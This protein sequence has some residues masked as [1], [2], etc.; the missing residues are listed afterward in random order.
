MMTAN[1]NLAGTTV[2]RE[3]IR[4][5]H[6][7]GQG[8]DDA[9][10]ALPLRPTILA[11]LTDL[12]QFEA[13]YPL[14]VHP[15]GTALPFREVVKE[16]E[17]AGIITS[18]FRTAMNGQS[19]VPL[20]DLAPAA[21]DS[22]VECSKAEVARLR[23][24][25]PAGAFL[26]GFHADSLVLLHAA[27]LA[28]A[29]R[30]QRTK[31]WE[32]V[33]HTASRLREIL[34]LD[35][36]H[37]PGAVSAASVT[38]S[39]GSR[40]GAFFNSALLAKAL[41]RPANPLKRMDAE[42]RSR[43][44]TTLAQLEEGLQDLASQPAFW[45][46]HSGIF[47]ATSAPAAV[48]LFH[49]DARFAVD[50]FAAALQ[51]CDTRL[52]RLTH[53]LRALRVARLEIESTFDPLIHEDMLARFDWQSASEAELNALPPIVVIETG[54]NLGQASLTSFGRL[55]R[56]GRPVQALILHGA[57]EPQDLRDFTPDFGYLAIAHRESFV[58]QSSM[59][60]PS[61]LLPGLAAM[62]KTLRPAVA[63]V[64]A[65]RREA[66][67]ERDAWLEECLQ[68]LS[69]AFPLYR[70]D[71]EA[72]ARWPERFQLLSHAATKD[73]LTA[74]HAAAVSDH[75][76]GQFR[77]L[78]PSAWN[79]EQMELPQYLEAYTQRP[80]LAIPYIWVEGENG[81]QQRAI[82][83]RDL[84]NFCVD[85]RRA[86]ALFDELGTVAKPQPVPDENARQEG[87][88]EAIQKVIAMLAGA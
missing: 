88:R 78:A 35:E 77:L 19:C 32:E 45:L 62:A 18:A 38:A 55:L 46:Y 39:L 1:A 51:F 14:C 41:Q 2:S 42:R 7:S 57:L 80:P 22:L 29:R 44:E 26:V 16:L 53:L 71:P 81:T 76:R 54:D 6:L 66:H 75:L 79:G 10:P 49:G 31:F 4:T 61:H 73:D 72:G 84:V 8:L 68:V 56:S 60:Q 36:A 74:A 28:E 59:A 33:R 64:A 63:V 23:K 50:S 37:A 86:W 48:A 30:A 13:S 65:P 34:L 24:L 27:A 52:D 11:Q 43:C 69:R 47:G 20:Q 21:I 15:D 25:L 85:R 83:T 87:E 67:D 5:F 12:P 40:V 3:Q 82:L 70:Y 17:H 9:I 58:L